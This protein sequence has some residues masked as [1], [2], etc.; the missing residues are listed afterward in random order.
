MNGTLVYFNVVNY[1]S[2]TRE[3]HYCYVCKL[4]I[5]I[6]TIMIMPVRI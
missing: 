2:M 3:C 1:N 4:K 6:A 5:H